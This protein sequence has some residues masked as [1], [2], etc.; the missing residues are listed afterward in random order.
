MASVLILWSA[1][2]YAP[3]ALASAEIQIVSPGG[4]TVP[5]WTVFRNGVQVSNGSGARVTF[6]VDHGTYKLTAV[7][8][9]NAG[10]T[11]VGE[12]T[13][14]TTGTHEVLASLN[15]PSTP[16][17][18]L[19]GALYSATFQTP[20]V[21]S[22]T[23]P[24][25]VFTSVQTAYLLPG[26]THVVYDLQPGASVDDEVIVRTSTGNYA[27]RGYPLG[28]S[29]DIL[30]YDY[31]GGNPVV[32]APDSGVLRYTVNVV[33]CRGTS[34]QPSSGRVRI[35]CYS[36]T[37]PVYKYTRCPLS[38]F[39]GGGGNRDRQFAVLFDQIDVET[40]IV[41]GANRA[42]PSGVRSY[43]ISA[44][45]Y[46]PLV[47]L[48]SN[49]LPDS[50][51]LGTNASYTS[52]NWLA[53]YESVSGDDVELDAL[54]VSG[55]D[56]QRPAHFSLNIQGDSPIVQRIKRLSGKMRVYLGK[57]S[58]LQNSTLTL[59]I[60]TSRK[61]NGAPVYTV[62]VPITSAVY[63]SDTNVFQQVA[64]AD[65]DLSDYQFSGSGVVVSVDVDESGAVKPSFP[66]SAPDAGGAPFTVYS[67]EYY[68]N[69][70]YDGACYTGAEL[71]S[72]VDGEVARNL[73]SVTGCS[74]PV[75]GPLGVY[76]YTDAYYGTTS[77]TFRQPLYAPATYVAYGTNPTVCYTSPVLVSEYS[78]TAVDD[79]VSVA[80]SALC[81][82]GW[83]Y[84]GCQ[85]SQSII[86]VFPKFT[87]AHS[88][89]AYNTSCYARTGTSAMS[90]SAVGY[91]YGTLGRSM[92]ASS[93]VTAVPDCF[94][95]ACSGS[96]VN[97]PSVAYTDTQTGS[98][99]YVN[100]SGASSSFPHT[101]VCPAASLLDSV[102]NPEGSATV[103]FVDQ[104]LIPL[105]TAVAAGYASVTLES[106][107]SNLLLE[108]GGSSVPFTPGGNTVILT[109]GQ[110]VYVRIPIINDRTRGQ[111]AKVSWKPFGQSVLPYQTATYFASSGTNIITRIDV[112]GRNANSFSSSYTSLPADTS[113]ASPNPEGV[114]TVQSSGAEYA[115]LRGTPTGEQ[116]A[117][118]PPNVVWYAGQPLAGTLTFRSYAVRKGGHGEI[119]VW[120]SQTQGVPPAFL[121]AG[122]YRML[123]RV[124]GP[125][126]T[127]SSVTDTRRS[128]VTVAA[129]GTESR[130]PYAYVSLDGERVVSSIYAGT[131]ARNGKAFAFSGTDTG[132]SAITSD[133]IFVS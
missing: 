68:K 70:L 58:L 132:I 83:S 37:S 63:V 34:A 10:S 95:L 42:G 47:T 41:A 98:R 88:V 117:P 3:G 44:P 35:R 53:T 71:Q 12:S 118:L 130:W 84:T 17:V 115:L 82:D 2:V 113:S 133:T 85:S 94:D 93:N 23:A 119:D 43:A 67:R 96:V 73:A 79:Y 106:G 18:V 39:S 8:T 45:A 122:P 38:S 124:A 19:L 77:A 121:A 111:A 102:V 33:K 114:F 109:P 54:T 92:V 5:T 126:R 28:A 32:P 76:C 105:F 52:S 66:C 65:I 55:R 59:R 62:S 80:S 27:L 125:L 97:G 123:S 22:L 104:S 89:I 127:S 101:G 50:A 81:G 56:G 49:G 69:A 112:T 20:Y 60:A 57:G 15:Q 40:D 78:G 29:S 6:Q 48:D 61:I 116:T 4:Y 36:Q 91:Q 99:V 14:W 120:L 25:N 1:P 87:A 129:Y 64:T 46:V 9:D 108:T 72:T 24:S 31:T 131:V 51:A 30:G 11:L 13:V 128:S 7:S 86:V 103:T 90:G 16:T 75:C 21:A 107:A 26:T 74:N 100:F 110:I